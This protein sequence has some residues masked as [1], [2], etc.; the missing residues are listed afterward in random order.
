[1]TSSRNVLIAGIFNWTNICFAKK[2]LVPLRALN[3][4]LVESGVSNQIV[5]LL[6]VDHV[7]DH[8]VNPV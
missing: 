7:G 1:M 6:F 2:A 4:N 8:W 5:I 3:L